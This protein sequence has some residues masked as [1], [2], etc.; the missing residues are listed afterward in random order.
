MSLK[1]T[2]GNQKDFSRP[3]S[4]D[5]RQGFIDFLAANGMTPD[6]KKGLVVGGDIGRAYMNVNGTNK[7]HGWY[8]FWLEQEVPYGRC[9]DRT[10]SNEEPTA[11]WKP[12][13]AGRYE[14]TDE[15]RE[16]IQENKRQAA[17]DKRKA[18]KEAAERAE[19]I[20]DTLSTDVSN[21]GYLIRKNV[22]GHGVR[23]TPTGELVVPVNKIKTKEKKKQ[24]VLVGLQYIHPDPEASL[25]KWYMKGTQAGGA[26]FIIGQDLLREAHTIN[27]VEGYA[28]GASYYRD[29]HEPVVVCFSAG[30][31]SK[32]APEISVRF[33]KAKHVFIAD[34]DASGTGEREAKKAAEF[35]QQAGSQA[36]VRMPLET[37]DYNDHSVEGELMPEL[38]TTQELQTYDWN[39]NSTGKMLM[40]KDNVRGVL[41]V[42]QIDVRYNVIKKN[43]E[44]HIPNTDHIMD[45]RDE[46]ALIEIE[47]R[48]IQLGVPH[49]KT[50]D[51]LKL[52]AKEYN[53]VK[54]FMER[55]PWDGTSRLNEFLATIKSS[56]EPLK[57][58]LMTKWLVSCV[59]AACEPSG[60]ALE[61]ILVFQG[62]QGLGKTLWF[63]NL[64]DYEEG[65]LLEGATLNPSD[66]DSVKQAVSHW[67]VE[68][69]EIEST[70]KK[71]DIDQLKA[72][73]TK[74][75][76]ELRLPY[77]RASTT[78]QRRTAFYASVNAR[79]FLT[80]TSGN[81]RFWVVPVVGINAQHGIN[82]QQLWA[83]VK[84]V[85][86]PTVSWYLSSEEREMLQDSNEYY[87]TQSSVED[88]ILEHVHFKST[89]TKPVQMTKLLRDLGISQPRMADIKDAARIISANGVEPRKS[90]GKKVYDLDYTAVE[91]GNAEKFSGGWNN[92][93]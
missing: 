41:T 18:Y 72:F 49:Q 42:N 86:Y 53:P 40:T 9:G 31:L 10:I 45:M 68:L 7:L 26:F 4:G 14:M 90:N 63:K 62:A 74:K 8:Q 85:L 22:T 73:V 48:C 34:N 76:D 71:S 89:Q 64:A 84:E 16:Q 91:V 51:Y 70:F 15:Q 66:K 1:I 37:G 25:G 57:E 2:D 21:N 82:M 87:R 93:F 56:N 24:V 23:Q 29:M 11:T 80:D 35:V 81:R 54:D 65:W 83:E 36:E 92:D 50:R 75:S 12:E 39:R 55:I 17:A 6:P 30:N 19:Q 43:M 5:A 79:E 38:Q 59:A 44:Y 67:I 52:L 60:V 33:P 58:M 13:N 47:D 69:G 46:S 32:V 28:T 88:L 77:D 3:L 61:G 20:W 78:Y 27:Y